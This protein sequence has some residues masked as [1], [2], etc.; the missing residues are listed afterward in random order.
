MK[1][2]GKQWFEDKWLAN[3]WDEKQA[4][5]RVEFRF[6]R[7]ALHEL[8]QGEAFH[9]LEDA[10]DLPGKLALLWAYAAGHFNGDAEGNPDGW[11]RYVVPSKKDTKRSRWP[12]HPT[13]KLIQGAFQE[14]CETPEQFGDV[15]RKRHYE[16]NIRKGVEAIIGYATSLASW[17]GG[18]LADP[19]ADLS[20]F[21]HWL[22]IHGQ[23]YL[24][25]KDLSFGAEVRRKRLIQGV[26]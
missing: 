23:N 8:S 24:S 1:R 14:G 17:I 5:W 4:V 7:E 26:Q 21:L 2:S 3:G 6:E 9:G 25:E 12:V 20:L 19:E 15:V 18:E 13:W 22:A 16:H 11:L 10:Y